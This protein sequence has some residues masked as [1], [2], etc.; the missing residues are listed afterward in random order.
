ME[1][2]IIVK[3]FM[4][5]DIYAERFMEIRFMDK[6]IKGRKDLWKTTF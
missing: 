1:N 5:K 6:D 2:D 4:E 3:R